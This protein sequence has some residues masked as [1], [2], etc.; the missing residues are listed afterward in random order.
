MRITVRYKILAYQQF[1]EMISKYLN[2]DKDKIVKKMWIIYIK[3]IVRIENTKR[4]K[5]K[6][7]IFLKIRFLPII[8]K[9]TTEMIKSFQNMLYIWK[10]DGDIWW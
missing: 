9:N 7:L 2:Q 10:S 8:K 3:I 6:I 1:S 5:F 4:Y